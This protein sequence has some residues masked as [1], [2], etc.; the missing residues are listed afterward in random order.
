[1]SNAANPATAARPTPATPQININAAPNNAIIISVVIIIT[2]L[3]FILSIK[4]T[5]NIA[6]RKGRE[7]EDP[8]PYF[9]V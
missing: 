4:E 1:M 9:S 8:T 7:S 5:V 6:N 3:L 2:I